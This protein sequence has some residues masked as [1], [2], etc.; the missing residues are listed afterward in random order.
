MG[1]LERVEGVLRNPR[2]GWCVRQHFR[3]E[4]GEILSG[5]MGVLEGR[6]QSKDAVGD[7]F[8]LESE[9]IEVPW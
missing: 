1:C 5:G 9:K 7:K 3:E 8:I 6:R 2:G 4:I